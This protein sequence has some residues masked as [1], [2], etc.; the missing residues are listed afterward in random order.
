[1]TLCVLV[2]VW[3]LEGTDRLAHER[4]IAGERTDGEDEWLIRIVPWF[5]RM[6]IGAEQ[7]SCKPAATSNRVSAVHGSSFAATSAKVNCKYSEV[8][9]DHAAPPSSVDPALWSITHLQ[10]VVWAKG[11]ATAAVNT[12]EGFRGGVK[13]DGIHRTGTGAFPTANAE[14]FSDNDTPAFALRVGACGT[15]KYT[16]SRITGQAGPRLKSCRQSAR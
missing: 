10:T 6:S 16:G 8:F 7:V 5:L 15:G 14:V 11:D 2:M 1:M 4:E 3:R 12:D 13:I 9:P